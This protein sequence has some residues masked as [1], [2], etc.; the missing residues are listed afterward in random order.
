MYIVIGAVKTA[1]CPTGKSG[2]IVI[3]RLNGLGHVESLVAGVSS[4]DDNC[5]P[6]QSVRLQEAMEFRDVST[7]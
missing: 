2:L 7:P 3:C 1:L 5:S 6:R 4:Q